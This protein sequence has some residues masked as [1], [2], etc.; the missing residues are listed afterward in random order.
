VLRL[1][2]TLGARGVLALVL[3]VS[4]LS[5]VAELPD[6]P[7]V[8]LASGRD[9]VA[10]QAD[11]PARPPAPFWEHQRKLTTVAG[12]GLRVVD[13]TLTC[14]TLRAGGREQ[15]LPVKSC[16]TVAAWILVEHG[17]QLAGE[18]VL[19]HRGHRRASRIL[20]WQGIG[21]SAAGIAWT[22]AHG[23]RWKPKVG[24]RYPVAGGSECWLD[25]TGERYVTR[26][27]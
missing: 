17:V 24:E 14:R 2:L 15:W 23:G 5:A 16:G 20:A 10:R 21:Q 18:W 7:S 26:C 27:P 19:W 9:I 6:A 8:N 11:S 22:A 25:W 13:I 12:V 1:Y 4:T 3:S